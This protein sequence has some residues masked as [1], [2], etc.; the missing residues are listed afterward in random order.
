MNKGFILAIILLLSIPFISNSQNVSNEGTDFWAVFPTHVAGG[1]SGT[2]VNN[3]ADISIFVTSKQNSE[4]TVSCGLYTET[5]AIPANTAIQFNV[6]WS[7]A[8]ISEQNNGL[9]NEAN[10]IL[11][12]RGIHVKVRDGMPKVSAY[13]HIYAGQRSAASLILPY[14]TLGQSYYSMNYTQ[15]SGGNNLLTIV[16][17][18]DNTTV[19]IHEKNGTDRRINFEK[20]GDV[21]EYLSGNSDLTGVYVEIDPTVTSCKR[22]AAFSGSSVIQIGNCS[23][24]Q[25]FDPLYQQLYPTV[26]WG[27]N[28]GV[29]PFVNR[30]YILR[31]L[32]KENNTIV[33]YNG[34]TST[35]NKG[36]F[37]ESEQLTQSTFV[38]AD[39]L[40]SVA[41]YSLT[42]SC[43]SAA[44]RNLIGDPEMV[45]LNPVEFNIKA[46]TVFSST[47]QDISERYINVLM[48]TRKTS[49][50]KI[51]GIAP[52]SPWVVAANPL[53][54][55]NQIPV[56]GATNGATFRSL[57]LTAED[58][59][60]AIAY[61]FGSAESYSYS[62]GTNL[63]SN[64]YLT[65]VNTDNSTESQNGCVG[66][67]MDF[68]VS[69]PY[70]PDKITWRL[71]G[72]V[73]EVTDIPVPEIKTVD[74]QTIYTYRYPVNKVYTEPAQDGLE[75]LAHVPN[76]EFNCTSGDLT[77]NYIFNV[78]AL[79]IADFEA[80]LNTCASKDVLFS[81]RS[82]PVSSDFSL[83]DWLWDFKDGA[84][85]TEQNPT[86]RFDT[87]GKFQVKLLVKSVSG[88]YSDPIEKEIEVFPLPVANFTAP[89][90]TCIN[91]DFTVQNSSSVSNALSVNTISGY[92][93]DF[94]DGT[95]ASTERNPRHSYTAAGN[96]TIK[97]TAT[98][99]RD[100]TSAE[101]TFNITVTD[102]P[103]ANFTMPDICLTDAVATFTNTSVN[104]PGSQGALTYLWDFG[105]GYLNAGNLSSNRSSDQNATHTYT[106][107]ASYQVTL[108]IT[109]ANGCVAVKTQE[110]VVNGRLPRA[111]FDVIT[112]DPLCSNDIVSIRNTSTVDF[113]KITKI[114]VYKDLIGDPTNFITFNLPFPNQIDL[115]YAPFGSPATNEYQIKL[116]AYSGGTCSDVLV[117]TITLKAVPMLLVDEFAPICEND[118][119][120]ILSQFRET[121]EIAG[122]SGV[123]SS[124]GNGVS[125]NGN[126]N[127]KQA[128]VGPHNITYT[129]LADNGCSSSV[130]RTIFVNPSPS[131]NTESTVFL[132]AGGEVKLPAV[133]SGD[134]LTYQWTPSIALSND[135][136][137]TPVAK[138]DEDTEY[139]L[140]VTANPSGCKA[141]AKILVKVLQVLTPPNSFTPNGDNVN[142]VWNIK[143]IESYP[144]VTIDV[145]NRNGGKV[146]SSKGYQNPFD[147][148]FQNEPLPVGV[149]YYIINPR[150]GRKAITGPLT[151]IR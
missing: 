136:I 72:G 90:V 120:V 104:S 76:N 98:S 53:Y 26:S 87:E 7:Q 31:I 12:N 114:E 86:H 43:S 145:F 27:K 19:L 110:F 45:M 134:D 128:G 38:T 44:G 55:Y 91:T 127:P 65:V 2:S 130:T 69:F 92:S 14:E 88:C 54:S 49:T 59:F 151:I 133:A 132:L 79:P 126:F 150:N 115:S 109:N 3:H 36:E 68:K 99:N 121:S 138:P 20:A 142:D 131:A 93:W 4:V 105:D 81:D 80:P 17:A 15:S 51:D 37:I 22:F 102:L 78:Y 94:G 29:V 42:Q 95:A 58:G 25:S 113:G 137:L 147:G 32:A 9:P 57:T 117:K 21:Y 1:N 60:N 146:F 6:A 124:D 47:L 34:Q 39:K 71:G 10:R 149:Y 123:Y 56:V 75:V 83:T 28:Y 74:G 73:P 118:G 33:T 103:I 48:L 46:V 40:I 30:R 23:G 101:K 125:A 116:V 82:N 108:T 16:A 122:D 11:I 96:Y 119:N 97:L 140:T 144:Q 18:D 106:V 148:N 64:N 62:A 141:T 112:T 67:A 13:A 50:F 100:C 107:A 143:Y 70:R 8:Y 66:Q 52:A 5:K 61:G 63:S 129:F 35:I 135:K 85:S 77:T 24:N 111:G 84:T 89:S 41:Q 139:T